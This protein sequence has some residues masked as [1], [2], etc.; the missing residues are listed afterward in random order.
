MYKVAEGVEHSIKHNLLLDAIFLLGKK[1][2][3][4]F[5]LKS[6]ESHSIKTWDEQVITYKYL[7]K[8]S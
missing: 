4:I 2:Q 1:R 5:D 3:T 8:S 6:V 7:G